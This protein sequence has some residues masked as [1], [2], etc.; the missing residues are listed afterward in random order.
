MTEFVNMD[1]WRGSGGKYGKFNPYTFENIVMFQISQCVA[2]GSVEWHG[3][4]WNQT[5]SANGIVSKVY[6]ENS[7][8]VFCNAVV[9]LRSLILGYFDEEM[10]KADE[11]YKQELQEAYDT[12][13]EEIEKGTEPTIAKANLFDK[14]IELHIFLFERLMLLIKKHN[15]FREVISEEIL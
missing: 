12:Y 3:G 8:E 1:S 6:V 10:K 9:M 5:T 15:Y 11:K 4:Y 14:K 13:N 2:K 7:R